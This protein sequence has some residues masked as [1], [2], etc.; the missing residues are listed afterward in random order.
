MYNID[1]VMYS[2]SYCCGDKFVF[3]KNDISIRGKTYKIEAGKY[4][5][6][7]R[8]TRTIYPLQVRRCVTK[9]V[10]KWDV[11]KVV[12]VIVDAMRL[13]YSENIEHCPSMRFLIVRVCSALGCEPTERLRDLYPSNEKSKQEF[14]FYGIIVPSLSLD[15][16]NCSYFIEWYKD[17]RRRARG[18]RNN[19]IGYEWKDWDDRWTEFWL[20]ENSV[21]IDDISKIER[22]NEIRIT[23]IMLKGEKMFFPRY[24]SKFDYEDH[25]ELLLMEDDEGNTHYVLVRDISMLLSSLHNT[26]QK[27]YYCLGCLNGFNSQERFDDAK[28]RK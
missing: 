11:D 26:Q 3:L 6:S 19:C 4:E 8:K 22:A 17:L 7:N 28:E 21:R 15:V 16:S 1:K 23:V 2:R 18:Q 5:L 25:M 10:N 9:Y 12:N 14:L 13:M 20:R 24:T 27:K